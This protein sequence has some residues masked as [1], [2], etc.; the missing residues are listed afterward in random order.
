M[1][2]GSGAMGVEALSRGADEC[3]FCDVSKAA[4]KAVS[5]N[6]APFEGSYTL[7]HGD[8]ERALELPGQYDFIFL[9]PPYKSG[10]YE[11]AI[12]RIMELD[13][14]KPNGKLI[15][16][17]DAP[18]PKVQCGL[19]TLREKKYGKTLVTFLGRIDEG[20]D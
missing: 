1:F 13:K 16:E 7:V 12:N 18:L 4:A 10:F 2:A 17:H 11:R 19:K 9:D 20:E 3:V 15:V 5:Q 14:L 8:F 6:A